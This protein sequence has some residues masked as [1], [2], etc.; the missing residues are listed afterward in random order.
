M[1]NGLLGILAKVSLVILSF[2]LLYYAFVGVTT[3][4]WEYDSLAYHIPISNLILSG[5]ILNPGNK[6]NPVYSIYEDRLMIYS[7]GASEIILSAFNFLHI[8]L[9]LFDVAG[10][11]FLFFVVK[12]LGE[13]YGLSHDTS[14]IFASTIST[15]HTITRWISTQ[16]ID[17]WLL[18]FFA[19]SIVLLRKQKQNYLHFF[20]LG[21]A[22]GMVL[23]SKYTGPVYVVFLLIIFGKD[24]IKKLNFTKFIAFLIP[25]SVLGLSWYFRNYILNGDPYFPQSIPFFKGIPFHMLDYPVWKTLFVWTQGPSTWLN[26]YFS[27]YS[28][29][30]LALPIVPVIFFLTRKLVKKDLKIE[31][32]KLFILGFLSYIIYFLLP[33][34]PFPQTVTSCLRYSYPAFI[35]FILCIFLYAKRFMK[36]EILAVIAVTCMLIMPELSYHPKVLIALVPV[37][38]LIFY[39]SKVKDF[40]KLAKKYY[41]RKSV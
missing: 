1:K 11:L 34:G 40:K 31:I 3:K 23:G 30:L 22:L 6:T 16:T 24:I 18:S 35:C 32:G 21:A 7:P 25:F 39:P 9:N 17:V 27:E 38:L 26:A 15:L 13:S 28:I 37:A 29:W 19:L 8:P 20:A 2:L 12:V 5:R 33:S 10:I 36:E 4:P 41:S 14:L